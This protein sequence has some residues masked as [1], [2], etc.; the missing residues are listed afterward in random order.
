VPWVVRVPDTKAHG[1]L[2]RDGARYFL[3]SIKSFP[4]SV[5]VVLPALRQLPSVKIRVAM[6]LAGAIRF[7]IDVVSQNHSVALR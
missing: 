3:N 7:A 5:L 1:S 2:R 6:C 4:E